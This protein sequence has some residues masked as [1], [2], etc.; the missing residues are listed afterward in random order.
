MLCMLCSWTHVFSQTPRNSA[1]WSDVKGYWSFNHPTD[2]WYDSSTYNNPLIPKGAAPTRVNAY[3]PDDYAI[4]TPA[5]SRQNH[6]QCT[7]KLAA[8]GGGA[9]VNQY[10]LLL[11]IKVPTLS[12]WYSLLQTNTSPNADDGDIFVDPNGKIGIGGAG[13]STRQIE[14]DEWVRIVF[15]CDNNTT[16]GVWKI[17]LDGELQVSLGGQGIDG[18]FALPTASQSFYFFADDGTENPPLQCAGIALW[19]KTLTDKEVQAIGG[20]N[21]PTSV[22]YPIQPFLQTPTSHS[23][24]VSWLNDAKNSS[25][26]NYGT[27]A[28]NLHI[29]KSTSWESIS[30]YT[31]HTVKLEN[32]TPSTTYYYQCVS[33]SDSSLVHSFR[34]P[35]VAG[36]DEKIII[37]LYSDI[38]IGADRNAAVVLQ[39]MQNTFI[40]LYGEQWHEH[41]TCI[42]SNGDVFQNAS[43]PELVFFY[44]NYIPPVGSRVPFMTTMGNHDLY[45]N[46]PTYYYQFLKYDDFSAFPHDS[47]LNEKYYSFI[48]G[49]SLFV[50]LNS[51][52]ATNT[53]QSNWLDNTLLEAQNNAAIDFVFINAHH[54]GKSEMWQTANNNWMQ[55][56]IYP[57]AAKYSKVAM[58]SHGHSHCYERGVIQSTHSDATDFRTL[59]VGGGGGWLDYWTD[60]SNATDWP[61]T[62]RTLE[63]SHFV[64][65]EIDMPTKSYEATMYSLGASSRTNTTTTIMD[66]FHGRKLQEAPNKPAAIFP[67]NIASNSPKLQAADMIGFDEVMSSQFQLTTTP[68]NYTAPIVN[69]LRD[70]ENIFKSSGA[71]DY[72]PIDKNA[73][74][75]LT[76][77]QISS[78]LQNGTTYAWRVRYRDKNLKWSEWSDEAIFTV[79]NSHNDCYSWQYDTVYFTDSFTW[80]D[81]KT[82]NQ[83]N[84]WTVYTEPSQS[85][86]E[87]I[88]VLYAQK[89]HSPY[90]TQHI[91]LEQGWNMI[92]FY[93]NPT[94][95]NIETIFNSII[96]NITIKTDDSFYSSLIPKELQSITQVECGK[97]YLLH[98]PKATTLLVEGTL[99]NVQNSN[100]NTGW[101]IIGIPVGQS[102][103]IQNLI[104]SLPIH[105]IKSFE[106]FY[107]KGSTLNSLHTLKPGKSYYIQAIDSTS[108]QW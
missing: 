71:P 104:N 49:N 76:S 81:G 106:G 98:S 25:I 102:V 87:D 73:G 17:F 94:D 18:R 86:C 80:I 107:T 43:L 88:L 29:Q 85:S 23:I 75:D 101:N 24:Y 84:T 67:R 103:D 6:L 1:L 100:L 68:G 40:E 20:Y 44:D 15:V 56:T 72:T 21:E 66:S 51:E 96:D 52:T 91:E 57:I 108:I 63:G 11:D 5:A 22:A 93:I 58:V 74:I 55:N 62:H 2:L 105:T 78:A 48:L 32:L 35:P 3:F 95:S 50:T 45:T 28:D 99:C 33:G 39:S 82:Y 34:T 38:H 90:V 14:A 79:Q 19:S 65:L 53:T 46:P 8:N 59:I 61:Q 27:Q 83:E 26:I 31:W 60:Y 97:G 89:T 92:S 7:P 64:I 37:A 69:S 9:K 77:Y 12:L 30:E 54:P 13:Y 36:A 70:Y 42:I 47:Q 10:T 16:N 41:V 4:Q